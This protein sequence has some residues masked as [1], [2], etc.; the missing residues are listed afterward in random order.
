MYEGDSSVAHRHRARER[1]ADWTTGGL[2]VYLLVVPAVVAFMA[3]PTLMAGAALG[4]I[5]YALGYRLARR[6]RRPPEGGL[7]PPEPSGRAA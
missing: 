1:H 4:V 7:S 5:V 6:F 3:V 2:A